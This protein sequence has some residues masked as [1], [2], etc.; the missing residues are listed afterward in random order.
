MGDWRLGKINM[1]Q[2][3]VRS[4]IRYPR[5][6]ITLHFRAHSRLKNFYDTAPPAHR[7]TGMQIGDGSMPPLFHR[8]LAPFV[9]RFARF[10]TFLSIRPNS[11]SL[12]DS[13]SH[14][15]SS[16][17]SPDDS[18]MKSFSKHMTTKT[19]ILGVV[20]ALFAMNLSPSSASTLDNHSKKTPVSRDSSYAKET[21]EFSAKIIGSIAMFFLLSRRRH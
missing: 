11:C 5:S 19:K 9:P 21:F 13:F 18:P 4:S 2:H 16:F 20:L 17:T 3:H 8:P 1:R 7:P 6:A 14:R 15:Q 10:V 12:C